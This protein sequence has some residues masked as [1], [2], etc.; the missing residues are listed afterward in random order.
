MSALTFVSLDQISQSEII[1]LM[2]D[3][4]VGRQL[5]LLASGFGAAECAA[6]LEAKRRMWR[7][8]GYGPQAILIDGVFAGWGG[9]QPEQGEADFALVLSPRFWG[10]GRRVFQEIRRR[11]FG[12]MGF[13]VITILLPPSRGDARAVRRFGFVANGEVRIGEAI[14]RRYRLSRPD[15]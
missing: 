9:L 6:F 1:A 8:H 7:E 14:F 4:A 5:P 2:N 13:S 15:A 3:P 10:W 12:P 11:A